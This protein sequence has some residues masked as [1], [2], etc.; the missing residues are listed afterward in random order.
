MD[1]AIPTRQLFSAFLL[2]GAFGLFGWSC[3]RYVSVMMKGRPFPGR[4]RD[5]PKRIGDVILFFFMQR[6]VAREWAFARAFLFQ[7]LD[8]HRSR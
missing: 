1:N 2:L 7:R 6:T 3:Q 5:I 4:F 8:L